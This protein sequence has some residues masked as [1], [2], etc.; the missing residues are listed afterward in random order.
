[1]KTFDYQQAFGAWDRTT[2]AMNAAIGEWF[3]LYY[4]SRG[5]EQSD[6]NQRIAYTVVHKL[7]KAVFAEYKASCDGNYNKILDTLQV[8][9][10]KAMQ[11]ALVG[12]ECYLK[13]YP[14]PGGFQFTLISRKNILVFGRNAM[15]DLTDVGTV[16]KSVRGKYYYTLLERRKLDKDGYLTIENKLY[17]SLNADHLGQNVP[18]TEHPDYRDLPVRWTFPERLRGV[19]LIRLKTPMLNCVD[20]STDGVSVY[21]AA[22]GLIRLIDENEAQLAGEFR[23]GQSRIIASRDMLDQNDQLT[24]TLFIGLDEDPEQV[25][26][27]V[28]APQLREQSYHARKQEYLRNIESV[29]GLQ[30]G[31]LSDANAMDRTA[32]EISASAGEYALTVIDFQQA[33]ERCMYE[34]LE[35]CSVLGKVYGIPMGKLRNLSVEWGNGVL[36]DEEELWQDFKDMVSM[37]M[38]APE[39]ALGWRF[40]MPCSTEEDRRA[41]REKYMTFAYGQA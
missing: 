32:T 1:M 39:V 34:V 3:S 36:Y 5:D 40:G 20:E 35:V 21:A 26:L 10:P 15:G 27:T 33:W 31:M 7:V 18:L 6:P 41:I 29:I 23:R 8:L 19:G 13:P 16:E 2:E 4:R 12:G 30:R 17:R 14:V 28:F 11:L 22:A 9:A 24:Q 37:G 25:G 38:L